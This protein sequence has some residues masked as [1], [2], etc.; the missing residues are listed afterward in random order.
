M[1]NWQDDTVEPEEESLDTIRRKELEKNDPISNINIFDFFKSKLSE[2]ESNAG[3]PQSFNNLILS[4]M[5][6]M[7]VY[8]VQKLIQ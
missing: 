7:I 8:Q 3:G 4:H 5:D 1:V 6:Q 2:L